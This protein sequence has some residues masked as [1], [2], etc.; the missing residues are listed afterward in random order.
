MDGPI[1]PAYISPT[2]LPNWSANTIKTSD[3]GINW[4]IVPDAAI[5]P[6]A[7]RGL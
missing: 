5:T 4:V 6:V 7:T 3:G 2:D 1:A